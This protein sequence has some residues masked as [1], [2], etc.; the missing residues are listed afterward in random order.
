MCAG[1]YMRA[2]HA[3]TQLFYLPFALLALL[4]GLLCVSARM[5]SPHLAADSAIGDTTLLVWVYVF[6]ALGALLS[7]RW[8]ASRA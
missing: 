2:G 5:A 3:R 1:V 8:D 4:A 7:P 6:G